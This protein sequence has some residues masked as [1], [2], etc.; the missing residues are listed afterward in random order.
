M[1]KNRRTSKSMS[2]MATN[3]MRFGAIIV[4]FFVMVILNILSSS[5]CTQL[6]KIKGQLERDL[7]ALDD[8]FM[9]ES[10]RWESMTTPELV[11]RAL[12]AK[13]LDMRPPKASQTVKM[14]TDGLPR[15]GQMSVAEARRRNAGRAAE[16][17]PAEQAVRGYR[18]SSRE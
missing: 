5:S 6:M 3:T 10:M 1:K 17:R 14:G 11:E 15:P 9:R 8:S 2:V 18:R 7:S 12:V 16:M 13:G 4:F